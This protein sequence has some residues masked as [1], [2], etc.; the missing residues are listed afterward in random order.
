MNSA[1][2]SDPIDTSSGLNLTSDSPPK[3]AIN[4]ALSNKTLTGGSLNNCPIGAVTPSTGVFTTLTATSDLDIDGVANLDAVDIDGAVQLDSTLTVGV[5]DTGYDVK[6]FGATSG[7]Y[8]LWDESRDDLILGGAARLGIGTID[9]DYL[10][11]INDDAATGVG[12][13]VTGGGGGG[14]LA[15]FTR[16]VSSSGSVEINIASG[17]PQFKLTSAGS[18]VFAVGLDDTDNAFQVCT[19]SAV[20]SNVAL[21]VISTGNVGIGETSPSYK[22]DVNGTGRFTGVLSA[23]SDLEVTGTVKE[24]NDAGNIVIQGGNGA[25]IELYGTGHSSAPSQANYDAN[26]HRFRPLDGSANS[27]NII[28]NGNVGLNVDALLT[29]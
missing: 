12:I 9:P 19:G 25:N 26:I 28:Q 10:L 1:T 17:D 3:I 8:M 7:A 6:F 20:G 29:S 4:T 13:R 22:L 18:D 16:D 27:L 15:R 21:A 11:D 14:P 2:F 24:P 5:D 23:N